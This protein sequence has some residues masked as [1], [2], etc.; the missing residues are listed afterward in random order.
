MTAEPLPSWFFP[1]LDG[2][3]A[4]D[5]DRLPPGA[6]RHIELIDGALVLMAPQS[7]F[8][9]RV[10]H[11]LLGLLDEQAPA[12]LEVATE[13]TVRLGPRQR[14]QPDLS[15]VDSAVL[16]QGRVTWL[17]PED[18]RLVIEVVSP[19]SEIRDRKRKPQLYAEAGICHFWRVEEGDDGLPVVFVYELDPAS[20][21]YIGT[22]VYRDELSVSV[23]FPITIRV[24]TLR[25]RRRL[26]LT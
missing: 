22:G 2:W 4:D 25:E 16:D 21:S 5:L 19:E 1:S 15:V 13:M 3:Y 14:P 6:P 23:P 12:E 24:N 20:Q 26:R 17:R 18:V 11:A 9:M 10:M 8:H 7:A